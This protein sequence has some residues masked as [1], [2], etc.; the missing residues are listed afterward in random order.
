MLH[1][2]GL[3]FFFC[4][5]L[6]MMNMNRYS[7]RSM[8]PPSRGGPPLNGPYRPPY[9][10]PGVGMG[11]DG[12]YPPGPPGGPGGYDYPRGYHSGP[13]T[14]PPGLG[15]MGPRGG[16]PPGMNGGGPGRD[17]GRDD[18]RASVAGGRA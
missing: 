8:S 5:C 13:P 4:R 17:R 3:L 18:R 12:P 15:G 9:P 7:R 2:H 11:P 16:I 14:G 10:P 1:A 6:A